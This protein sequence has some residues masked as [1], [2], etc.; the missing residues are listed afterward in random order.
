MDIPIQ[1]MNCDGGLW[2]AI[3]IGLYFNEDGGLEAC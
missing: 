1:P 3:A 2:M